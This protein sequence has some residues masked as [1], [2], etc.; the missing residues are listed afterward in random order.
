[1]YDPLSNSE[2]RAS[3]VARAFQVAASIAADEG[4]K[5]SPLLDGGPQRKQINE[6]K[7]A[8]AHQR[9]AQAES[10]E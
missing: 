1:M 9:R 4:A 3:Q 7:I 5:P 6:T 8:K 2:W 10:V